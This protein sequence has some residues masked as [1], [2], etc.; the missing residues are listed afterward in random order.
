MGFLMLAAD[1]VGPT[2]PSCPLIILS[3]CFSMIQFWFS[4]KVLVRAVNTYLIVPNFS[5]SLFQC[6]C[7]PNGN[8]H[9]PGFPAAPSPEWGGAWSFCIC[10]EDA[11]TSSTHDSDRGESRTSVMWWRASSFPVGPN[12]T[13]ACIQMC[14]SLVNVIVFILEISSKHVSSIRRW[15]KS[16]R[17]S[18]TLTTML[19]L[20]FIKEQMGGGPKGG[21]NP[22][23]IET[24]HH[25]TSM[26]TI[27]PDQMGI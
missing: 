25:V 24:C 10:P 9:C 14:S 1:G 4:Q 20:F 11:A 15:S 22:V 8:L 19:L 26:G 16:G 12:L 21:L 18:S 7:G 17:Q 2:I 23:P 6:W 27:H 5:L 13:G 3:F